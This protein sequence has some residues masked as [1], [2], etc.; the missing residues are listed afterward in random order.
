MVVTHEEPGCGEETEPLCIV[1][2]YPNG[3][4]FRGQAAH[5]RT[6]VAC[7]QGSYPHAIDADSHLLGVLRQRRNDVELPVAENIVHLGAAAE[8]RGGPGG[9]YSSSDVYEISESSHCVSHPGIVW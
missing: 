7:A 6:S 5:R 1:D 4:G 9:G 8:Q 3:R 2:L